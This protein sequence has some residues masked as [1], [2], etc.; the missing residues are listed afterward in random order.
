MG[1]TSYKLDACTNE[2]SDAFSLPDGVP[3]A[4]QFRYSMQ[5][6]L[7]VSSRKTIECLLNSENTAGPEVFS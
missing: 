5:S 2:Y 6:F 3:R 4:L 7:T 1:G